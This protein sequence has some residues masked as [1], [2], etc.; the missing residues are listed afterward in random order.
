MPPHDLLCLIRAIGVH[1]EV[2]REPILVRQA[3][4]NRRIVVYTNNGADFGVIARHERSG[5][6][7]HHM[8]DLVYGPLMQVAH[9]FVARW[10]L[11]PNLPRFRVLA[12]HSGRR[13]CELASARPHSLPA[14]EVALHFSQTLRRGRPASCATLTACGRLAYTQ[15]GAMILA[16]AA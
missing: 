14:R 13:L 4:K 5:S 11:L 8:R 1:N 16:T 2:L 10:W 7:A 15:L 3:I 6:L 12:E 9:A